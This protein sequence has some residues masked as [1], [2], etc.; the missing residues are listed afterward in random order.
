[1]RQRQRDAELLVAQQRSLDRRVIE[2]DAPE[3]NI[4]A[5]L[6]Q[7]RELLSVVISSSVN[8]TSGRA[9]RYRRMTSGR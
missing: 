4:D 8:S 5:S 9:A 2:G 3:A 6:L 7:R 1:V